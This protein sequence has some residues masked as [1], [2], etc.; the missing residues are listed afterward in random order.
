MKYKIP[1]FKHILSGTFLTV[2]LKLLLMLFLEI[3]LGDN[4]P[5]INLFQLKHLHCLKLFNKP[6]NKKH[7]CN[8]NVL[9]S[10]LVYGLG[11]VLGD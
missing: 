2:L 7:Y 9:S 4:L 6:S 5:S 8:P 3:T 11:H 10:G 1:Q